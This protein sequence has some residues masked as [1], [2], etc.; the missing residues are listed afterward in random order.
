MASS[1][2]RNQSWNLQSFLDSLIFEL[3]KARDTLA[4]KGV[5]KPLTYAVKDLNLDLQLFPEFDGNQVKFTTAKPGESGASRISISLGSITDRQIRETTRVSASKDDL[6]LDE[7]E[8]LE[9][10]VKDELKKMGVQ[11]VTD[12][13]NLEARNI[14]LAKVA[15]T[16]SNTIG[17]L[18]SKL[19][20][21]RNKKNYQQ[22]MSLS[23]SQRQ[24]APPQVAA[25]RMKREGGD[26]LLTLSGQHLAT[27]PDFRPFATL[28][29]VPARVEQTS[30]QEA[31]IRIPGS[32]FKP[33]PNDFRLA[34]DPF[35]IIRLNLQ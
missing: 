11:S 26:A 31:V 7:V 33:G 15:P 20:A 9:P 25:V 21:L 22:Q 12:L 5:N 16:T 3:D 4:I 2:H 32:A 8:D 14:D 29:D 13:E 6:I 23:Q 17:D 18:A 24:Q 10:E 28:N 27:R 1:I 30:E 35:A 19:K 34:L